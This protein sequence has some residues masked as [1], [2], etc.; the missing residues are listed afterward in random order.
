MVLDFKSLTIFPETL[1]LMR[2]SKGATEDD[3]HRS[4]PRLF[5]VPLDFFLC[6]IS[7]VAPLAA[8][9]SRLANLPANKKSPGSIFIEPGLRVC[10]C[11][12]GFV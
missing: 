1:S 10:N 3:L 5:L 11:S 9:S 7:L 6:W 8:Q 2:N 12:Y 4:S